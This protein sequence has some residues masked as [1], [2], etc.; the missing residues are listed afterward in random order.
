VST[1]RPE[2]VN[3]QPLI[4]RTQEW[5]DND[6]SVWEAA[7][8][9][10][11]WR[12]AFIKLAGGLAELTSPPRRPLI[13]HPQVPSPPPLSTWRTAWE[14]LSAHEIET[15]Q[16]QAAQVRLPAPVPPAVIWESVQQSA[17][18]RDA[19]LDELIARGRVDLPPAEAPWSSPDADV[20]GDIRAA[21]QA[22]YDA[23]RPDDWGAPCTVNVQHR[24][25]ECNGYHLDESDI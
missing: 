4:E 7:E 16:S 10:K 24:A 21:K 15:V 13:V 3:S 20:I 17:R 5:L 14:G 11:E 18:N 9:L 23:P 22:A 8:L 2:I 12:D 25:D 6:G 1:E 19:L